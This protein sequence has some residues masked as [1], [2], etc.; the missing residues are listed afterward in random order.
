MGFFTQI[1]LGS[2]LDE[3]ASLRSVQGHEAANTSIE[4]QVSWSPLCSGG[5]NFKTAKLE[6]QG[7]S[8][9]VKKSIGGLLF[10][11]VFFIPG[12]LVLCLGCPYVLMSGEPIAAI[13]L[14]IWGIAFTAVGWFSLGINRRL[15]IDL[16]QGVYYRGR[17]QTDVEDYRK[18]GQLKDVAALQVLTELVTSSSE[19]TTSRFY[20]YELNLVLNNAKRV[21]IMD[22]GNKTALDKDAYTVASALGIPVL[23]R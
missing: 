1:N 13:F 17:W 19:G 2:E 22:H 4:K 11:L 8:L 12:I 3:A 7:Q 16:K 18:Q 9:M 21:N 15:I 10:A 20:S 14:T 6:Q 23:R 5:S